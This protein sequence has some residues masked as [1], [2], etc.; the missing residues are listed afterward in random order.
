MLL[1]WIIEKQK[2]IAAPLPFS[3]FSPVRSQR[4][5][6][7]PPSRSLNNLTTSPF[8][9]GRPEIAATYVSVGS[10]LAFIFPN[11]FFPVLPVLP[12]I[13]SSIVP[14]TS[15]SPL[16]VAGNRKDRAFFHRFTSQTEAHPPPSA[17][18]TY[19]DRDD[20]P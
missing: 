17:T 1:G 4:V 16:L 12:V 3:S 10:R 5:I 7:T 18:M 8:L 2:Q 19:R 20:L 15:S 13:S 14:P 11:A 9:L 6:A